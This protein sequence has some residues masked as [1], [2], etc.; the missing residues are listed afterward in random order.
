MRRNREVRSPWRTED[1]PI[2][3]WCGQGR[4][5]LQDWR[6]VKLYDYYLCF[7]HIA[8]RVSP[9][10]REL[11]YLEPPLVT[12]LQTFPNLV[13]IN[14]MCNLPFTSF[15][16]I[17]FFGSALT[18]AACVHSPIFATDRLLHRDDFTG[19]LQQWVVEQKPGGVVRVKDGALEIDDAAGCTVWFRERLNAPVVITYET[20]F[21]EA[22]GPNDRVSDMNCFWMASDPRHPTSLFY[23]GHMRTGQFTSYNTLMTYYVSYGGNFNTTTRFRRYDGTGARPLLPEHE[24]TG[25]QFM[26]EGGKPYHIQLEAHLDGTIRYL[27]NG[28]LIY[29]WKDPQPIT[30]GWFGFRTVNSHQRIRNFA[31]RRPT[32]NAQ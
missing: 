29:E 12:V 14:I 13:P 31:V 10:I 27:R 11:R 2:A 30:E 22:G 18:I 21:I 6:S 3:A 32:P 19:D 4:D 24:R 5:I 9:C 26:L 25:P 8:R 17:F 7:P 28:V 16:R 1:G 15:R 20:T 23:E